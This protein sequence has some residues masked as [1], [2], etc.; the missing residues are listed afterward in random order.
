MPVGKGRVDFA[1]L[2]GLLRESGYLGDFGVEYIDSIDL[3]TGSTEASG[4]VEAV[5]QAEKAGSDAVGRFSR[6]EREVLAM[7]AL[8]EKEAQARL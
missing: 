5:G 2:F 4:P 1:R 3:A 8:A 6:V 7:H